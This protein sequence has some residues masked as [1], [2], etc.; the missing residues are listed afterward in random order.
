M[1]RPGSAAVQI[2]SYAAQEPLMETEHGHVPHVSIEAKLIKRA[3]CAA[4]F[5]RHLQ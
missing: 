5:W 2:A 3:R 1:S 4:T